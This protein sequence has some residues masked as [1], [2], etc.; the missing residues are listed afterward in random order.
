MRLS[1]VSGLQKIGNLGE[2]LPKVSSPNR[3]N[4]RFRGD[5]WRRL[6]RSPLSGRVGSAFRNLMVRPRSAPP[7][8]PGYPLRCDP[9]ARSRMIQLG[10]QVDGEIEPHQVAAKEQVAEID[11]RA[12]AVADD[13][14]QF[15]DRGC[16][17]HSKMAGKLDVRLADGECLLDVAEIGVARRQ[18]FQDRPV[19]RRL[20]LFLRIAF[21]LGI[22]R[23]FRSGSRSSPPDE[24]NPSGDAD[25]RRGDSRRLALPPAARPAAA[26]PMARLSSSVT[27]IDAECVS[28]SARLSASVNQRRSSGCGDDRAA[29]PVP[30]AG[31]QP[32]VSQKVERMADG[33]AADAGIPR[34]AHRAPAGGR[35]AAIRRWR[36]AAAA[37]PRPA[38][39]SRCRGAADAPPPVAP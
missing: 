33:D 29:A 38:D 6:V 8:L 34:P 20:A 26:A 30:M 19:A 21:E 1:K 32:L 10:F 17:M 25:A 28:S 18:P 11:D 12:A 15:G 39:R 16:L 2:N 7:I 22:D 31:D 14:A 13:A 9:C 35:P 37:P 4:S 27:V 24:G 5:D 3:R 23:G 36:C